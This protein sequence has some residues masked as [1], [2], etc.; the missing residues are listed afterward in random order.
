MREQLWEDVID[1]S[2]HM[3]EPWDVIGDFNSVLHPNERIGGNLIEEGDIRDSALCLQ[4]SE[5]HKVKSI[6]VF[7]SW[8]N[9]RVWSRI[10]RILANELWYELFDFT[11][12]EYVSEPSFRSHT[13]GAHFPSLP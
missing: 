6:G 10:D 3:S 13:T 8:N 1:I 11:H 4:R 12:L 7:F 2:L 9:K 5:L